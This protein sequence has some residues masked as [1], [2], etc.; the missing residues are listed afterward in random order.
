MNIPL[1]ITQ[2]V[3]SKTGVRLMARI[4]GGGVLLTQASVTSITAA[5]TDLNLDAALSGSGLISTTALTISAVI[6]DQLQWDLT[7]Q[8]DGPNNPAPMPPAGDGAYGFNFAWTAPAANFANGG[9]R[10]AVDV[11]I[12]PVLGEQ[13][14]LPFEFPTFP[15]YA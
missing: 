8:K 12:V 1:T 2:A 6:F 14:V 3:P 10:Y 5:I 9:H 13:F 11:T 15:V 4:R 7:W